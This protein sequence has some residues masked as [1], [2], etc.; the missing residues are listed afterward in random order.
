MINIAVANAAGVGWTDRCQKR[1]QSQAGCDF[2]RLGSMFPTPIE[3]WPKIFRRR[4]EL[5]SFIF[6]AA[7]RGGNSRGISVAR[8]P[9]LPALLLT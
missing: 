6:A 3:R 7:F 5:E 8:L 4:G 9:L 1:V 2:R